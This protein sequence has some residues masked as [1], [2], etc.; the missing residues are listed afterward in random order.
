[1]KSKCAVEHCTN[2]HFILES[3]FKVL[4]RY[5]NIQLVSSQLLIFTRSKCPFYPASPYLI[6]AV[7]SLS[8]I[9]NVYKFLLFRRVLVNINLRLLPLGS[10]N[11]ADVTS[12]NIQT[13]NQTALASPFIKM[14]FDGE[15]SFHY[16]L[17]LHVTCLYVVPTS[18]AMSFMR[19]LMAYYSLLESSP[20]SRS[21]GGA[22]ASSPSV[23]DPTDLKDSYVSLLSLD[24][25]Q[26]RLSSVSGAVGYAMGF[27]AHS[28]NSLFT[29]GL[30]SSCQLYG[31]LV[32]E[33][34]FHFCK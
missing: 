26:D 8:F 2:R 11:S 32:I 23:A 31:T 15:R 18:E 17:T 16:S 25:H 1:M 12:N 4:C 20:G 3:E 5:Y 9:T 33:I 19:E 24:S 30:G 27:D 34:I 6:V 10:P 14:E 7:Y 13:N 28:G 29:N 21:S 22:A